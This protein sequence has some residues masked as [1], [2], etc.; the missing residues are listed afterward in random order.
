MVE[1][2]PVQSAL[3]SPGGNTFFSR[4]SWGRELDGGSE[5]IVKLL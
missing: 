1:L 2:E 3:S 4:A 5:K